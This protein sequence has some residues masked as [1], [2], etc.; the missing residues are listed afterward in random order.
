MAEPDPDA[1]HGIKLVVKDYPYAVDGLELWDAIKTWNEE[2]VDIFYKDDEAVRSDVE[3]AN[4]WDEIRNVGHFDKRNAD[5]WPTLD[6]KASLSCQHAAVNFGQYAYAGFTPH[7]PTLT[8]R[9]F[10]DEGT[11][12]WEDVKRAPEKFYLSTISDRE[13]ATRTMS[14]YEILSSH[15]P[16]E[17]YIGE[18]E[19]QIEDKKVLYL[20]LMYIFE[21]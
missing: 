6:S 2:Y 20:T 3:L 12:E 15:A 8:R 14:V 10:P 16:G 18:R 5:G 13:S 4:W 17:V 21:L 9:L 11:K 1:K 19:S 7:H